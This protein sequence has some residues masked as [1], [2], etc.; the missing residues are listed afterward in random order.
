MVAC[1][2][3]V[4]ELAPSPFGELYYDETMCELGAAKWIRE[5]N[6]PPTLLCM[7]TKIVNSLFKIVLEYLL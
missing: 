1:A 2:R 3:T 6:G 7:K 4:I 5:S